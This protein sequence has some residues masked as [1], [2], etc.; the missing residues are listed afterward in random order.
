MK[1]KTISLIA[2]LCNNRFTCSYKFISAPL[3]VFTAADTRHRGGSA[4]IACGSVGT[5]ATSPSQPS[6]VFLQRLHL[7]LP[8]LLS[9]FLHFFHLSFFFPPSINRIILSPFSFFLH[10][11][12]LVTY[13]PTVSSKNTPYTRPS[14]VIL[15]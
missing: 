2:Y 12:L 13:Y 8:S 5:A 15:S 6:D 4:P 7:C 11:S 1:G 3:Q 9:I 10:P 14:S